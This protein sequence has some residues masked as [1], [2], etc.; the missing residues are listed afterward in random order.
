MKNDATAID[1][2]PS[3]SRLSAVLQNLTKKPD[4]DEF[5][6]ENIRSLLDPEINPK[7]IGFFQRLNTYLYQF[8]H[9]TKL[10]DRDIRS[11]RTNQ[12][13]YLLLYLCGLVAV[14]I[15]LLV[16]ETAQF[17]KSGLAETW[18]LMFLYSL[19]LL[20]GIMFSHKTFKKIKLINDSRKKLFEKAADVIHACEQ[21]NVAMFLDKNNGTAPDFDKEL[22]LALELKELL[23]TE[24][25]TISRS[26]DKYLVQNEHFN[27][28]NLAG[29]IRAHHALY[30]NR[31]KTDAEHAQ[32]QR[33][34]YFQFADESELNGSLVR[35][36]EE[37][38]LEH[39]IDQ[40]KSLHKFYS[41]RLLD[42]Q[43]KKKKA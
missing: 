20:T 2:E 6:K 14:P 28:L 15:W 5:F 13:L 3:V 18:T 23:A 27:Y 29:I 16:L 7:D 38:I 31:I 30:S 19:V 40:I 9:Y 17:G 37:E 43:S 10:I 11:W 35:N 25:P 41:L 21:Y 36:I 26:Y 22:N 39:H 12:I 42:M 34:E 24:F 32:R 33:D 4:A 8:T 1:A